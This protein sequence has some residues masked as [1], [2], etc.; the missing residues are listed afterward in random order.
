MSTHDSGTAAGGS[1]PRDA[2]T[3][4]RWFLA[5][6]AVLLVAALGVAS[7]LWSGEDEHLQGAGDAAAAT[8]GAP[9]PPEETVIPAPP[10]PEPTGPTEN[11][12]ALPVSLPEVALGEPAAVGNGVV[13]SIADLEA[14][15]GTAVGPGNLAGPALRVTVRI[16]NGTGAPVSVAGVAVN[17]YHGRD[18]VPASPLEDP[19]QRPFVGMLEPGDSADGVYVFTVPAD[20]RD[21]VTVEVGYEAGAALLFFTGAAP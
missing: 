8:T 21:V 17:L 2:S 5:G 3:R 14:I 9:T 11:A 19:S 15:E 7:L 6:V 1:S 16:E 10:T 18:K 12:N 4:R 13:A 20:Q